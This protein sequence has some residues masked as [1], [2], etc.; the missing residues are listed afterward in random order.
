MSLATPP[1]HEMAALQLRTAAARLMADI[2]A[3]ES[4][5]AAV[6]KA[7]VFTGEGAFSA[8]RAAT[9]WL[10]SMG[11]S[12]GRM[13]A[14]SPQGILFGEFDIQKWRNLNPAQRAVLHG[15]MIAGRTAA[16]VHFSHNLPR[17]AVEAVKAGIISR[18]AAATARACAMPEEA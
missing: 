2:D 17:E 7:H 13:Q 1:I 4:L 5:H 14:R 9:D 16:S 3:A 11:F 15:Q 12:V 18:I 6:F 8:M 10:R